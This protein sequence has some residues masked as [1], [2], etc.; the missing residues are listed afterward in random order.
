MKLL[1]DTHVLLWW[2]DA[3]KKLSSEARRAIRDETNSVFVSAA[4]V[5]EII[6]KKSL[7]KLTVPDN[8]EEVIAA[9]GFEPLNIT[10]AHASALEGLPKHH[11]D[12]FDRI[13]I[14]QALHEGLTL[15]NRDAEI[16]KY[17][18]SQMLA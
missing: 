9:N 4:V 7:G 6:I 16:G 1:L 2:L 8:L 13:L 17:A 14:A 3:P 11:R 5:W 10:L 12:P 15:V 18:V